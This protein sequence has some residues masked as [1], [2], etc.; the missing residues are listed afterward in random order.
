MKDE[1]DDIKTAAD[2]SFEKQEFYNWCEANE[3]D[4]A[5]ESMNDDDRKGF[6][7]IERHFT[8]AV[9][10]KRLAVDGDNFVYTVSEKSPNAGEKFTVRRPNG[11]AMLAM[12]GF[13]ETAGNQKLQNFIAAICGVEKRDIAKIAG[14][15]RKDYRL[16]EDV[17]I[18]FLTD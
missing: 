4:H 9:K 16:L 15:D 2:N 10:E 3:I 13:K 7:K 1:K 12:D 8:A 11:R 5:V 14:L 17:A 6:E 18:L